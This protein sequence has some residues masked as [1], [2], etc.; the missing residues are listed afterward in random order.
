M[1]GRSMLVKLFFCSAAVAQVLCISMDAAI[2][3][4][5]L[6]VAPSPREHRDLV[7]A[8]HVD[9]RDFRTPDGHAIRNV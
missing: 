9:R 5:I 6:S 3:L 1:H 8:A 4:L 7:V 2:A